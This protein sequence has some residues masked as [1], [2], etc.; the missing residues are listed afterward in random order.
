VTLTSASSGSA[1]PF[2]FGQVFKKGAIPAGRTAVLDTP[3][4]QVTPI[5][6][7]DDGSVK[8]ALVAG[9]AD[10]SANS[11]KTVT[12]SLG[13]AAAG[14][15]L[16]E[17][18]LIAA[19]PQA[20]I[21]YGSYGTVNLTA[22][23][24][25]AARV[26]VEQAGPEYAAFQYIGAFPNDSSV[27]AVFY[28]QL[29]AGGKYRVRVAVE[30]GTAPASS[31]AKSGS[32]TV[33][34]AG[35]TQFSGAVS[36]PQGVRWDVS[37]SNSTAITVAH[38]AAYLR[39]SKLVP[40]YGYLQANAATLAALSSSYTPMARL[41]WQQDMGTTGY[42]EGIGLLP[43]W[44]AVYATTGDARALK[45]SIAHSSAFGSYSIFYR[46]TATKAFPTFND[47]PSGVNG[48]DTDSFTGSGSNSN[49]W[50]V[51]HHPNAGYLAW[52]MTG[53]RFH[54]ETLEANAWAAWYS[55]S[56]RGTTG[57]NKVFGGQTRSRAW[58]F[59]TIAAAAAVAPDG[60]PIKSD[61]KANILVNIR[62]WK[63]DSVVPNTPVTGLAATAE[64]NEPSITGY[65]RSLFEHFFLTAAIGWSWDQEML[66]STTDKADFTQVR[67]FFYRIPVGLTGRGPASGEY[68]YRRG[69]GPYRTTIGPDSTRNFYT[70][71][72]QVYNATFTT[73][74]DCSP[75]Q[76]IQE[77]YADD[78][79]PDSFPQSN[80]GHLM[81]ALS[82]AVDHG[83]AGASDSYARVTG[84]S[85]WASNA[86]NFNNWPQYGVVKRK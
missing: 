19:S 11:A 71:W 52:L 46:N 30:N 37:G 48:G 33:T 36:M 76:S 21:S 56:L 66:L 41:S 6:T 59:R 12:V 69:P 72:V 45:S 77:A 78:T 86:Q 74:L 29:W 23:L 63:A 22:L 85:N 44:D 3:F 51:A 61:A 54:L 81:T 26:R 38:D 2:S 47:F 35:A 20:A 40:N 24:G 39:A 34:I 68:C 79:S 5:S 58:R 83:A 84:A 50:E 15:A 62:Q 57:V 75:G 25:T 42:T 67:D 53:E 64:D 8:H 27:R 73:T 16:S 55:E 14:A 4:S 18:N 7:W 31:T 80:W 49:R 17:T 9:R 28:V 1:L 60:E 32:A 10:F 65:Q 82:Y 70:S 43:H 13:T